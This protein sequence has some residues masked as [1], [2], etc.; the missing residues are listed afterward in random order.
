MKDR[1]T[2]YGQTKDRQKD[3]Q[4]TDKGYYSGSSQV[5]IGSK[6]LRANHDL[7]L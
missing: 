1:W 3:R 6:I 2:D 5:K 4:A 7:K